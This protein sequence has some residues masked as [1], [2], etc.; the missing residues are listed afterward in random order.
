MAELGC[1]PAGNDS[2]VRVLSFPSVP[3][4]LCGAGCQA[5]GAGALVGW[6]GGG[7]PCSAKE[8]PREPLPVRLKFAGCGEQWWEQKS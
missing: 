6:G 3:T 4:Q 2:Q 8:L 7:Q 1:R 5:L